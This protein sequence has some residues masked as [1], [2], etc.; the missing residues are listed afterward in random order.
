MKRIVNVSGGKDSTALYLVAL[1]HG[2]PFQA[3]F[4]DTGH[5]H[6]ATYEYVHTLAERT[7]GPEV[8]VVRADFS[9]RLARKRKNLPEK[10]GKLGVP[11]H[12]VARALDILHPSGNPFVDLC[13]THGG[14][15][16][17]R[18]RFCTGELK[19]EPCEHQVY[20]PL[21][22]AGHWIVVWLGVRRAESIARR[23]LSTRQRINGKSCTYRLFRPLLDW[24]RE[25]VLRKHADHGIKANPLYSMGFTRV[26]CFPCI[27]ASKPEIRLIAERFPEAIDKLEEWERIVNAGTRSDSATFFN[28]NR[29]PLFVL[30]PGDKY[31]NHGIRSMVEWA[32]T[33]HGGRQRPLTVMDGDRER[34]FLESTTKAQ[35]DFQEAC[36]E[37]GVCE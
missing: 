13:L 7:G 16:G 33:A 2:R 3:V 14:F 4:A 11:D 19:I 22:A 29:D 6:P 8:Q 30:Q 36:N 24:T 10:W 17:T 35:R 26:G 27:F 37:T 9:E 34:P 18:F 21:I 15:P 5:E 28:A 20:K 23:D 31:A 12:V 32:S 1:E 25:Q